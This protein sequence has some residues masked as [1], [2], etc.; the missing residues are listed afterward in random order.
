TGWSGALAFP[1]LSAPRA[2]R[3]S[4]QLQSRLPL[5]TRKRAKTAHGN[6][7]FSMRATGRA[8]RRDF[9]VRKTGDSGWRRPEEGRAPAE[10]ANRNRPAGE[11]GEK[12]RRW[13]F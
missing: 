5:I 11:S 10:R 4:S 13:K 9:Q 7:N 12:N 1:L 2:R 8:G 6:Q 3:I